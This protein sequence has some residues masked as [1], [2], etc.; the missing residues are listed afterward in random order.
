MN[1][2]LA[3]L[4]CALLLFG[5]LAGTATLA[6]DAGTTGAHK[7][8]GIKTQSWKFGAS[9]SRKDALWRRSVNPREMRD[10]ATPGSKPKVPDN[11][12][13][14]TGSI[15]SA[16]QGQRTSGKT[17]HKDGLGMSWKREKSDWHSHPNTL[18][19]PDESLPVQSRHR[20][21]AFADMDAGDDLNIS[22]GPELI[23]K[24]RQGSPYATSKTEQP[25][26]SVGMGMQFELGF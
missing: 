24:D 18:H 13:D 8:K 20:V 2:R 3:A 15:D 19:E 5:C 23:L 16:L 26:S 17:H 9:E 6:A 10:R 14:T 1:A 4:L 21:R 12:V 11:S 25:D 7:Q 22:V